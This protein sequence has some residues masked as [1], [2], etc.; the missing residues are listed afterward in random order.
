MISAILL[1]NISQTVYNLMT[2]LYNLKY[3]YSPYN[4][5][6]PND[7]TDEKGK[8]YGPYDQMLSTFDLCN[9]TLDALYG[10][11]K[12]YE[13]I[14]E[15]SSNVHYLQD[16]ICD[17]AFK[18]GFS[19]GKKYSL[20]QASEPLEPFYENYLQAQ[21]KINKDAGSEYYSKIVDNLTAIKDKLENLNCNAREVFDKLDHFIPTLDRRF[22]ILCGLAYSYGADLAAGKLPAHLLEEFE[23]ICFCHSL[24]EA[25]ELE[26]TFV[27]GFRLGMKLCVESLYDP[28]T[29]G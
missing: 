26:N 18:Q 19:N 16:V 20:S 17:L 28:Y 10:K 12:D 8:A 6:I 2:G 29:F 25:T 9:E 24:V 4:D 21:L 15:I 13:E 1:N 14:E 27:Q 3:F 7:L 11:R 5:Y 22:S 23:K